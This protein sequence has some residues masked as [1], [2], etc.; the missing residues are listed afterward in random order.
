MEVHHHMQLIKE[1][2][3][4]HNEAAGIHEWGHQLYHSPYL[5]APLLL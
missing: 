3:R 2:E 4:T 5:E 1:R